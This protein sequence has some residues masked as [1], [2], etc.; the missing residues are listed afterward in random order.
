VTPTQT[1]PAATV[2]V[3]PAP[4]L[5]RFASFSLFAAV[6][7]FALIVFGGIVR[8]TD[9]GMG[10][11]DDWPKCN[12][13]WI[14]EF[15]LPTLIEYTHRLL[16][17]SIGLVLIGVFAYAFMRRREAGFTGRGGVLRIAT[18]VLVLVIVQGLLGAVT[19]WLEIP[20]IVV[21]VHFATALIIMALLLIG[22]VR[23]RGY[24][25]RRNDVVTAAH[26]NAHSA[27]IAVALGF[28]VV[29]FGALVA[30]NPGAPQACQ[31]FP[32]CNGSI[33]PSGRGLVQLHWL[34]RLVAFALFFY[35]LYAAHLTWRRSGSAHVRY[36]AA[37]AAAAVVAQIAVA[38]ALVLLHLPPEL[39]A[40][41]LGVG[42]MVWGSLILWAAYARG[43]VMTRVSG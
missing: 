34:H 16:G 25:P 19:V 20:P 42:A 10:C 26:A 36:T 6:Y 43:E 37:A 33:L 4:Y 21:A 35:V 7:T 15:T 31:G 14:P 39:Q 9:S 41:H 5:R 38:A 11:G 28:V 27:T 13:S 17:V 12:G 32:L 2:A 24:P 29:V 23:G 1:M 30:N 8:I 3:R 18:L 22:Y 40:L